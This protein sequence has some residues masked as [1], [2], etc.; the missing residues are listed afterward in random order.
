MPSPPLRGFTQAEFEIRTERAQR[1]MRDLEV[2]AMLL[3][4]E[5][6]VR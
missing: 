3:T 6:Q 1:M 4:T 5:P 2:D